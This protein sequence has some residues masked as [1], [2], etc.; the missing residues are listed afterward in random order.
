MSAEFSAIIQRQHLEAVYFCPLILTILGTLRLHSTSA[1]G[2][3]EGRGAAV[4]DA[5]QFI[6]VSVLEYSCIELR[7]RRRVENRV[8]P[9]EVPPSH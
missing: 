6:K 3:R 1:A 2:A 7:S 8:W 9:R 4:L 5:G